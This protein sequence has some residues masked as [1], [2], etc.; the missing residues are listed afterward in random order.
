MEYNEFFRQIGKKIQQLSKIFGDKIASFEFERN[1]FGDISVYIDK[2]AQEIVVESIIKES[3]KCTLLSEESGFLDFGQK[4]PLF[5]VD[6]IDGSLNATRGIPY[7]AFSIAKATSASSNSIQE[8]YV[9][10]LSTSDE[11]FAAKSNGAYLNTKQIKKLSLKNRIAAIEGIKQQTNLD[12]L[13]NIYKSFYRVRSMGS[14][15]LDM[16]YLACGSIDAFFHIQPSRII[17]FAAAKLIVEESGGAL[18]EFS[19]KNP[20]NIPIDQE[21]HKPFWAVADILDLDE[22]YTIVFGGN[23]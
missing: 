14:V 6:P 8:A 23:L 7:S 15:A 21:K 9:L 10:N 1:P 13:K 12:D 19:S 18:F 11:F 16:C 4:Y 22:Y 20:Y 5:I 3:I 2:K 17:D